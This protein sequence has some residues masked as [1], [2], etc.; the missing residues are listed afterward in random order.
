MKVDAYRCD[1]CNALVTAD[2]AVGIIGIRDMFNQLES[3]PMVV[4]PSKAYIHHCTECSRTNVILKAQELSPREK[5][6]RAYELR[7]RE[8]YAIFRA[9]CVLLYGQRKKVKK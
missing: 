7:F 5:D 1:Y 2:D 6:E 4:N 9:K 8:L 3:Y